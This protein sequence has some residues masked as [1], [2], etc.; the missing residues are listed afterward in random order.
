MAVN[1]YLMGRL[2]GKKGAK[3][4][5]GAKPSTIPYETMPLKQ[6][7]LI[8]NMKTV[9]TG[10]FRIPPSLMKKVTKTIN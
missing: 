3:I 6:L 7:N 10:E 1:H 2:T 8:L 5:R 9:K 4:L